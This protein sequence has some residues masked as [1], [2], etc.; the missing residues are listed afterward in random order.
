M[1]NDYIVKDISLA[2]FGR[3]ELDIA[4]TEMPGLMACR[5]EY[6]ES[7]PL[8][9]ARIVGSLH[10]TIQTAVLIE[11][12]VELG[13]DVR[14]ASCNIFSTQ[15]HAAAA[16][17]E[18]GTPVFAIKG[19]SL[20][21][22]WDYLD[23]SFA[24]SEGAN[25]IL[26]DGGDATLYILL[27]A[28]MEAGEDVLA[29]PTSEEE[30]VI[31]A[32]IQKRMAATPGWFTKTRGDILG[33]SEETTTGVHRLYDL[34]KNGQL[35]F[36]AINVND[37]V[38]KSK[39][40]N[41]YGCKESLVDGIRRATDTMM[42]G[43]VAV[44]MGYGDVGKGSAASLAGAGA[45]VIVTEVDPICALQAAMDGFQVTTLDDVVE[46]ADLFVTT[47]GN[48]DVIRIEHMR[49][50]KDM[51][52]V[53]NIGHFDNEIQ[54]AALKNHKWTN[55]KEQVDMIEM[56]NGHR[57]I[58]LSEGRLLNLGNATGHP[59][60]VMSAS[61]TNQVLAQIELF[62]KGDEYQPGVYILPKHLDEKVARLHLDRIGVK[63]SKLNPEQA[64]YIGVTPE[65]PFKPEHYRY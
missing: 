2:A 58:L 5:T 47:T 19:Q 20:E 7:K 39:F 13:A 6:G 52:I 54:V 21:E 16:I 12:L 53:G 29:V 18:G 46:T 35:P 60:F 17:A 36:P 64:A 9:G 33:V 26:D 40:D 44:V 3:K 14:W 50:M 59:S 49:R 43:K 42:A 15:D 51:A 57:L 27:G 37:S 10:M 28:R 55:I 4:E 48:K 24:F 22:H 62:T 23:K 34:H 31:K 41:K 45:R 11:T 61:F 8:K 32:Q 65:G 25:M 38:T 63:L 56:P 30:E 1:A